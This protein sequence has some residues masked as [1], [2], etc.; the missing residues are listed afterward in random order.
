LIGAAT[1]VLTESVVYLVVYLMSGDGND[2]GVVAAVVL[3]VIASPFCL[4]AAV[5]AGWASNPE[6]NL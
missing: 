4:I 5:L 2:M 3:C 6:I 1:F